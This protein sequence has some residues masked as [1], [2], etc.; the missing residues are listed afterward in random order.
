MCRL[1]EAWL[2]LLFYSPPY[3]SVTSFHR[4]QVGFLTVAPPFGAYLS[5]MLIT[6]DYSIATSVAP[7]ITIVSNPKVLPDSN[8]LLYNITWS[9]VRYNIT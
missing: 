8:I 9:D 2:Y 5:G 7:G 1:F 6:I 3:H 4:F